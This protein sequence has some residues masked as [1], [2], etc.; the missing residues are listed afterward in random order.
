MERTRVD[1]IE[2][3]GLTFYGYHGAYAEE[4][5]LGQRFVVDLDLG[6]DLQAAGRTDDLG[7]TVDYG[8]VV[9]AVRDIVE[10]PP[11]RLIEAL[12]EA[13]AAAIL[14]AHPPVLTVA[15]RVAKPSA[16]VPASAS[17]LIAVRITRQR[18]RSGGEPAGADLD[19]TGEDLPSSGSVLSAAGIARLLVADPPLVEPVA[20]RAIQIQPNGFDLTLESVWRFDGPGAIGPTNAERVLPLRSSVPPADDGWFDLSPGTYMIR[21]HETVALPR[22]L[23]AFGRPRSSLL[24]CGAAIHTAVWDAGYQGR[25]EALM[26]VHAESGFRLAPG[27]RVLQLVF[28]RL[29]EPTVPYAGTYQGENRAAL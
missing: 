2:L 7:R 29:T 25:S 24:R 1:T 12:A 20:D 17:G 28:V 27:A 8:K 3:H 19:S 11:F 22:D 14:Q 15:V 26:V 10:G 6:V 13:L 21:F 18:D 23:M 16:P 9:E 5:K 4:Q